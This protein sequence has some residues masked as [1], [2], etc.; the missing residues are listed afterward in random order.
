MPWAI[1]PMKWRL[2]SNPMTS[3]A[4]IQ[5]M[6]KKNTSII[7]ENP[8]TPEFINI[9]ISLKDSL[10]NVKPQFLPTSIVDPIQ[11]NIVFL[12]LF[13]QATAASKANFD[14]LYIPFR[15]IASDVYNK[16]PLILKKEIWEMPYVPP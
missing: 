5:V 15:C 6:W 10:K 14:S 3:N 12:Q 16:R 13:G 9:R 7:Q 11:M 2:Y 1:L 4:G 8:P